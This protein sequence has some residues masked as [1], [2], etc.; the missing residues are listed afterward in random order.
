MTVN[1]VT[2]VVDSGNYSAAVLALLLDGQFSGVSVSYDEIA[3]RM[4][5]SSPT[6]IS[7]SGSI[8]DVLDI[9]AGDGT[10]FT[11]NSNVDLSGVK[12]IHVTSDLQTDHIC[13]QG[14]RGLLASVQM[15]VPPFH[16]LYYND[17][18]QVQATTISDRHLQDW[19][20]EL[21]DDRWRP[22]LCSASWICVLNV[23]QVYSGV[24]DLKRERPI[25]LTA[26][27]N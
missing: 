24:R 22:L 7:L 1:G 13:T 16:L 6:S 9:T 2:G 5:I 11:S 4:T 23:E 25:S 17:A 14:K 10:S 20:I 19:G 8:L 15:S 26:K 21:L 27:Y 18:A 12:Q 3:G